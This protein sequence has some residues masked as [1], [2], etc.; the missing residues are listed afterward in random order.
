MPASTAAAKAGRAPT[1]GGD[2][3]MSHFSYLLYLEQCAG[4][5][6]SMGKYEQAD[7]IRAK[8]REI[9]DAATCSICRIQ[10]GGVPCTKR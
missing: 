10:L 7:L 6:E 3:F 2:T 1:P 5:W 4:S 8:S 9:H